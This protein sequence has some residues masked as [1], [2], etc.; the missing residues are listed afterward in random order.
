MVSLISRALYISEKTSLY[1]R[2]RILLCI[3][4]KTKWLYIGKEA[5]FEKNRIKNRTV[6]YHRKNRIKYGMEL[7]NYTYLL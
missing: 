1:L 4:N 3:N 7:W 2:N 5:V 6:N